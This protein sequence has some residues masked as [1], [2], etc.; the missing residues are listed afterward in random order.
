MINTEENFRSLNPN[1]PSFI[2][3]FHC[4]E[5]RNWDVVL[6]WVR[7]QGY[8]DTVIMDLEN[9]DMHRQECGSFLL[10]IDLP[11]RLENMKIFS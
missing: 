5:K 8:F 9:K 6:L 2:T 3:V 7:R 1:T 11:S 10:E 4:F